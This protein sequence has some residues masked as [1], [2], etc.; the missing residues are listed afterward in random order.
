LNIYGPFKGSVH[1]SRL[2]YRSSVPSWLAE[3]EIFLLGDKV[4]N[5]FYEI[6]SPKKRKS[7]NQRLP[8]KDRL[9]NKKIAQFWVRIENYFAKLKRWKVLSHYYHGKLELHP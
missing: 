8:I 4:Y 1:D 7:K 9:K 2:F 6:T 5:G 3:N